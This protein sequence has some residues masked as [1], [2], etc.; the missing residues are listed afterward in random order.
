MGQGIG[1]CP[2]YNIKP[3]IRRMRAKDWNPRDKLLIHKKEL[4]YN[5]FVS[6]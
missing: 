6:W 5:D 3:C 2:F 1:L 4:C